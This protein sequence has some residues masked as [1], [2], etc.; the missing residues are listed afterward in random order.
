MKKI[1]RTPDSR[2]AN[3]PGYPFSPHYLEVDG[4][5]IHYVEEGPKRGPT[6]LLL[7]GE[8][9]WSYLYRKMIP[10]LAEA[11]F[12]TIAPDLVGFGRSDKPAAAGDYSYRLQVDVFTK[13]V[14]RLGLK[15]TTLFCQDWGGLIGLR[16]AADEPDR[17]ARIIA[18]NTSLPDA[19]GL[20]SSIGRILFRLLVRLQGRVSLERLDEYAAKNPFMAFIGWVAFSRTI[21]EFPVGE[22]MQKGT[23][24]NLTPEVKAA[25]DAP[26][27]DESYKAGARVMPILVPTQLKENR[28]AWNEVFLRWNKPFL[29]LF[30]E[31]DPITR[32][33]ERIFQRRIPGAKGRPH[34]VIKEASHFLQ[35]DKGEELAKA[36]IDFILSTP[37]LSEGS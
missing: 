9:S 18:A 20:V 25:Y 12:R 10:P 13:F 31:R 17:F 34:K 30:S 4:L 8:P 19:C 27:P 23:W 28:K 2:F 36:V 22:I 16:V 21:P 1:L 37:A 29:T 6:V 7:H 33:G 5:R 24:T 3:L 35:E 14:Q 11:G 26:F 15:E 32:G